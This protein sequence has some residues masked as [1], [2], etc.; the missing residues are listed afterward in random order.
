MLRPE[1]MNS[2]RVKKMLSK[3]VEKT[4]MLG[5]PDIDRISHVLYVN[6]VM[7]LLTGSKNGRKVTYKLNKPF[8]GM[9]CVSVM[10]TKIDFT[11][12]KAFKEAVELSNNFEVYPRVDGSLQMNFTFYGMIK[13]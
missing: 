9:G 8:K 1:L 12:D 10:C 13:K 11:D 6:E 3:E 5:E 7:K 4:S 2:E